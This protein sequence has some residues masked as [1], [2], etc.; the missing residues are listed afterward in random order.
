LA[1]PR[2]ASDAPVLVESMND[3]KL[4]MSSAREQTPRP[5]TSIA[6]R[7]R[8]RSISASAAAS[9]PA[10]ASQNRRWSSAAAATLTKRSPAVPAHQPAKARLEQGPTTRLSAA[11][12]RQAPT[13]AAASA[14]RGPTTS[15]AMPTTPSLSS[16]RHAAAR[17]PNARCLLPVGIRVA[18]AIAAA[19]SAAAPRQVCSTTRGSPSTRAEVA[20]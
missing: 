11:S 3:A 16:T 19:I 10:V 5:K 13:E 18:P 8:R 6:R 9:K 2:W 1:L 7:A 14:R 20:R 17:S 12:A 4:A 15:S